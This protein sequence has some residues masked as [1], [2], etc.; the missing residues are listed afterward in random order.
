[1]PQVRAIASASLTQIQKNPW[2]GTGKADDEAAQNLM[3]ADIKR[4][5]ER[6]AAPITSPSTFDAPPGAPI[7]ET[8]M[9]WLQVPSWC[10]W[11]DGGN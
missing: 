6:P 10:A 1:M 2:L 8:G 11:K 7:G 5:L 3:A 4:F 9:E